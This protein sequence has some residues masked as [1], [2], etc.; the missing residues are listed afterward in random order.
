MRGREKGL[1]YRKMEGNYGER[2]EEMKEK[3]KI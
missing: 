1:V 3:R 2:K